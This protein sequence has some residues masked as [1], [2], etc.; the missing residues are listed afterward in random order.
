MDKR[1][2]RVQ[3]HHITYSPERCVVIFQGEHF[4]LTQMQRR[5]YV[6]YG[7]IKAVEYEL[8]RMLSGKVWRLKKYW[9][10]KMD[11]KKLKKRKKR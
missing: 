1:L 11:A 4:I 10:M 5:K 9:K 8:G 3:R 2:A 7:F 6:S